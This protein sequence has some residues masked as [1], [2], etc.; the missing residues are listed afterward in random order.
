M[1]ITSFGIG[2]GEKG[3]PGVYTRVSYYINWINSV[4]DGIKSIKEDQIDSPGANSMKN[5]LKSLKFYLFSSLIFSLIS[6]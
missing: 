6:L 3:E 5:R 2:C 1:G 4:I